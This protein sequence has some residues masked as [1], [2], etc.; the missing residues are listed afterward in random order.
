MYMYTYTYIHLARSWIIVKH[1]SYWDVSSSLAVAAGT[2][3]LHVLPVL[4]RKC[5]FG[6]LRTFFMPSIAES[7]HGNRTLTA[8]SHF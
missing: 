5:V 6:K 2:V 8:S 4:D 3:C 7:L 1:T